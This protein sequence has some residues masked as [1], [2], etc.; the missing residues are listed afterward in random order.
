MNAKISWSIGLLLVCAGGQGFAWTDLGGGDHGGSNWVIAGGVLIA[1][2]HYNIGTVTIATGATVT[3]SKYDGARYG[4]VALNAAT[5]T[6]SGT[7]TASGSGYSGGYGG[8]GG[9]GSSVNNSMGGS[10]SAGAGGSGPFAGG[11]GAAGPAGIMNANGGTGGVGGQGGYATNGLQGDT[12]T[13]EVLYMGSGG[14]GGGGG[15]SGYRYMTSSAGGGGGGAGYSGGGSITLIAS[16][17]IIVRGSILACGKTTGNGQQGQTGNPGYGGGGGSIMVSGQSQAGSRS[18]GVA[19]ECYPAGDGGNG[20]KGAGGGIL[21]KAPN[22][23]LAGATI[24]NRGGGNTV[25]NG[26]SLKVFYLEYQG[27]SLTNTGRAYLKQTQPPEA[28]TV[29]EF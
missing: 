24:D 5:I 18:D 12:T 17:A 28:G 27:G 14:G 6:I 25:A 1:S 7:L 19:N 29:F 15:G 4:S 21:I 10:G 2:N 13:N 26:G 23:D 11:A 22:V 20:G 3:V 8:A 16:N 9:N